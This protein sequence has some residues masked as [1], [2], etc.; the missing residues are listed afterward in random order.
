MT[1]FQDFSQK[2]DSCSVAVRFR[3]AM[4]AEVV[5]ASG[6]SVVNQIVPLIDLWGKRAVELSHLLETA[7]QPSQ[8]IQLLAEALPIDEARTPL[9]HAIGKLESSQGQLSIDSAAAIARLST[10]QFRRL[11]L[12]ATGLSPKMLARILRFRRATVLAS[13]MARRHAELAVEC[14]YADQSHLIAE[15][16]EFAGRTPTE[17]AETS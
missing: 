15:C 17:L 3:P 13:F 8:F 5:L 9:Q 12:E 4:W 14:G 11:C 16:R 2:A 10:R 1:H 7:S 6:S